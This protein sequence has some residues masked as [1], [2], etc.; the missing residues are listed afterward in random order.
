MPSSKRILNYFIYA[1]LLVVVLTLIV[2]WVRISGYKTL[3][4][5]PEKK[6]SNAQNEIYW[7]LTE[8]MAV[9]DWHRLD[10]TLKFIEAEYDCADFRLVNLLRIIY[11]YDASIPEDYR[12]KIERVLFGFRYWWDLPGQNSMCYWTENHQILFASAEYLVG[13][14]YP[15]EVFGSGF[16]G[17]Q[18]KERARKRVLDWL[19]MRWNYGFTE[20]YSSV[21]YKE[22]IGALINLIDFAQDEEVVLK[23]KMVMD[24]LFY[25]IAAQNIH[26]MFISTSGRAYARNRTGSSGSRFGGIPNYYWGEGTPIKPGIMYGLMTTNNYKLPPVLRAIA[27]DTSAVVIKQQ[28]GLDISELKSEGYFGTDNRSMMMQWGMQAF[29]NPEVVRNSLYTVRKHLSFA[30]ASVAPMQLLDIT[31]LNWL[32]LEPTIIRMINPPSNGI[33]IQK[34]NTYT[35]KTNDYTMYTSQAYHPGTYSYQQH[36]FGANIGNHFAIF[37]THPARRESIKNQSPGYDIGY[38]RLPHAVQHQ[39]VSLAIYQTP[40]KKNLMEPELIDFTRAYFPTAKFDSAFIVANYAFGQKGETYCAFIGANDFHLAPGATDDL[41]QPGR[42]TFWITEVSAQSDEGS[43]AAFV[44]R[45]RSNVVHFSPEN[46]D[47]GYTSSGKTYALQFK[48]EFLV[49]HSPINTAYARFDAPYSYAEPK[50]KSLTFSHKGHSLHL[51]FE[52]MIREIR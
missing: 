22:D 37:H 5:N 49:N 28:N 3:P 50:A 40:Q 8:G 42:Q 51:H 41:I 10:Q 47:L 35:Y 21:Y 12:Q 38:G 43:F 29:S 45:I 25:D 13:Q 27:K 30:N 46:K 34:G 36:V 44:E 6:H 15:D 48:K 14:K 24:L 4:M 9:R 20:Y 17:S 16:T 1:L 52:D 26:T 19:E 18:H 39:N 23:C 33:A 31:L 11:D 2:D 7:E 32:H